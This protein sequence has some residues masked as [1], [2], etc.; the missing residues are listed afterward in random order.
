MARMVPVGKGS[1]AVANEAVSEGEWGGTSA[2]W[3]ALRSAAA[4]GSEIWTE[5]N[6]TMG[7]VSEDLSGRMTMRDSRSIGVLC[8][9][10]HCSK[11]QL[12]IAR[13][14]QSILLQ[15]L[16]ARNFYESW[17]TGVILLYG[18]ESDIKRYVANAKKNDRA[19]IASFEELREKGALEG[20]PKP[21]A[22]FE[23]GID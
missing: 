2:E 19:E 8:H 21:S 15:Y 14:S 16:I 5:I 3:Q 7:L 18:D 17:C 4:L 13:Q 12:E 6:R 1:D 23:E 11:N 22:G 9:L 10:M 20:I